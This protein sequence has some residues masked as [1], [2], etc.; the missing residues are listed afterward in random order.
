[1]E[2]CLKHIE[3]EEKDL[4]SFIPV[5]KGRILGIWEPTTEYP[6]GI[7]YTGIHEVRKKN[8]HIL[9]L[10][11]NLIL[12]NQ[13]TLQK[14]AS[15]KREAEYI[16]DKNSR[17]H[18]IVRIGNKITRKGYI[19]NITDKK[20]TY[21]LSG[22]I[23]AEDKHYKSMVITWNKYSSKLK[24]SKYTIYDNINNKLMSYNK[25]IYD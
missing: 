4:L 21:L 10:E 15:V 22:S 14:I 24:E 16:I 19:T 20:I 3:I 1:M 11:Q 2:K 18:C 25:I 8:K 6:D 7:I 23:F 12:Y 5:G 13:V 9:L 17:C